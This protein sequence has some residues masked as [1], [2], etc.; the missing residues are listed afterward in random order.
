LRASSSSTARSIYN[1]GKP[2]NHDFLDSAHR[3]GRLPEESRR[4]HRLEKSRQE[5][6]AAI[7]LASHPRRLFNIDARPAEFLRRSS[8]KARYLRSFCPEFEG[9]LFAIRAPWE[10]IPRTAACRPRK[11]HGGGTDLEGVRLDSGAVEVEAPPH[12]CAWGGAVAPTS[13]SPTTYQ[14]DRRGEV[15]PNV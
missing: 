2:S 12:D 4:M 8:G 10:T 9:I 7:R 14:D 6:L 13:D 15:V 1:I 11:P 3:F 5:R